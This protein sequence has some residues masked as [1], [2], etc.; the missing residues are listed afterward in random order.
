MIKEK[1]LNKNFLKWLKLQ[2]K[3]GYNLSVEIDEILILID[4]IFNYLIKYYNTNQD[5]LSEYIDNLKYILSDKELNLLKCEYKSDICHTYQ[6][7]NGKTICNKTYISLLIQQINNF[8]NN[9]IFYIHIDSKTGIVEEDPFFKLTQSNIKLEELINQIKMN[10]YVKFDISKLEQCIYNHNIDLQ[11]RDKIFQIIIFKL[12]TNIT[13][14]Q[15]NQLIDELNKNIPNLNI[16]D[17][18]KKKLLNKINCGI[19]K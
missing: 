11:L 13:N 7:S 14:N 17:K 8:N 9:L 5:N 15:I 10:K 6:I 16:Q 3:K 18:C 1:Q 4:K 2:I 19:I 12:Y